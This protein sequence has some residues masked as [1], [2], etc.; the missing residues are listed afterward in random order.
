MKG[1]D[2]VTDR[3]NLRVLLA[4]VCG[5]KRTR[6]LRIGVKV[7]QS[8][9]MFTCWNRKTTNYISGFDGYGHEAERAWTKKPN[10]IRDSVIHNRVV[11]YNFGG[12]NLILRFEVDA[13][14]GSTNDVLGYKPVISTYET[15]TGYTVRNQGYLV[16]SSRLVEIKTGTQRRISKSADQ[17]WFSKTPFLC[18][19]RYTGDGIFSPASQVNF[20]QDGKL[21]KWENENREK[22]MKLVTLLET[23]M[24]MVRAAPQGT[25]ALV[26]LPGE[27]ILK[28]HKASD[29]YDK[30]LPEDLLTMWKSDET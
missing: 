6:S 29:T 15:P 13:C 20:I 19:G 11:H 22:L 2:L 16:D 18:K 9:V 30:D 8:T 23:I 7:V 26:I 12:I 27:P 28:L 3:N 4:F 1:I 24:E 21:E 5:Q 17:L 14:R 25:Y 10:F